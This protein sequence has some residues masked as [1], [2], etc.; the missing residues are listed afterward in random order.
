LRIVVNHLTRMAAPRICVA[1]VD[2]EHNRHVRPVTPLADALT[3]A[4]LAEN[5]GPM[6]LGAVLELGDARPTPSPPET[7]D[8]LVATR[9][10]RRIGELDADEY[11][12]LL[13]G[14][15]EPHLEAAFGDELE[16]RGWKYAV[17]RGNGSGSLA[18]VKRRQIEI[19][20]DD[21]HGKLRLQFKDPSGRADLGVTDLR[22]CEDDH[23]TVRLDAVRDIQQRLRRGV[24]AYLMLGLA[25]AFRAEGDDRE[26]HWL[27][28]NG[29]CMEDRPL[30]TLP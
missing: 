23:Q 21:T 26:R 2:L 10:L 30:G 24:G 19:G 3:R 20:V 11:L 5:D 17:E 22:L 25:R 15:C 29:I 4:L 16:H 6:Q 9:D 8:H 18:V 14:V 27:Q 28:V 1:G 7:E 13:H 12:D